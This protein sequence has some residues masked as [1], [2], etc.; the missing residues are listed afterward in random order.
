MIPS[1][2]LTCPPSIPQGLDLRPESS[3]D[4][5][6]T[7]HVTALW[8]SLDQTL[9]VQNTGVPSSRVV[10]LSLK[11]IGP[12]RRIARQSMLSS[13]V[14]AQCLWGGLHGNAALSV[15]TEWSLD[16]DGSAFSRGNG[17]PR[18]H[19]VAGKLAINDRFSRRSGLVRHC[20]E[21]FRTANQNQ[22]DN[23]DSVS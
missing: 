6:L 4:G 17:C 1:Q 16:F 23:I 13:L 5:V 11:V 9:G 19:C 8:F 7:H 14:A 20:F 12:M 22:G 10:S 21:L 15:P 3:P 2:F 18:I